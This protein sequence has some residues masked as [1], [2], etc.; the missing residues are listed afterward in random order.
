M[1]GADLPG[2]RR[3]T[4]AVKV[5]DYVYLVGGWDEW[6]HEGLAS[7]VRARIL[8]DGRLDHEGTNQPVW[9]EMSSQLSTPRYAHAVVSAEAGGK[10]FLYAIG[11]THA[12]MPMAT[13]HRTIERAEVFA[14]GDLAEWETLATLLPQ[15]SG[16]TSMA[17]YV[18]GGYVYTAGGYFGNSTLT[19]VVQRAAINPDGTLEPF[20]ELPQAAWPTAREGPA[21]IVAD[22]A[23]YLIS[24]YLPAVWPDADW[25]HET[26][27]ASLDADGLPQWGSGPL[28]NVARQYPAAAAFNGRIY[29]V[30]GV[31]SF[32]QGQWGG[33]TVEVLGA[34]GDC[35][36]ST[37]ETTTPT[38][39]PTPTETTP[40]TA[41]FTAMPPAATS[42]STPV[43][44]TRTAT[45][46]PSSATATPTPRPHGVGG[47]VLLPAAA[48][49]DASSGASGDS[50]QSVATWIVLAA[51]IA[52][53][54]A[55]GGWYANKRLR[56]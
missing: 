26:D 35:S 23:L 32:Y 21:W 16:L 43:P 8:S 46:V 12:F 11:G 28:V 55:T 20:S 25:R 5:G 3:L 22:G 15:T 45:L 24:G 29:G 36:A 14:N 41:T 42:T 31:E 52:G 38:A 33:K 47:K 51:A 17:A 34:S 40:P 27:I 48:V 49:A 54:L 50:G 10:T 19:N 56:G 4:N 39:T 7:T 30:G 37:S 1:Q 2:V 6:D 18:A 44:P 53:V 13:A 9:E